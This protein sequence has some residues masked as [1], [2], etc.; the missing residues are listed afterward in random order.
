MGD[1]FSGIERMDSM[2]IDCISM[3]EDTLQHGDSKKQD[4]TAKLRRKP[5]KADP[6]LDRMG[7]PTSW[8]IQA[9]SSKFKCNWTPEPTDFYNPL[10]DQDFDEF[11]ESLD[12]LE[13]LDNLE[14]WLDDVS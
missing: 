4:L 6:R 9:C 2:L 12:K 7:Q 10:F 8:I 1:M 13:P 5:E 14:D 11:M 3:A